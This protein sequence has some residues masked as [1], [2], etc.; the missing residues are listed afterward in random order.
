[1]SN[2]RTSMLFSKRTAN[3]HA[4]LLFSHAYGPRHKCLQSRPQ[5]GFLMPI[6]REP[7]PDL[8]ERRLLPK[9]RDR[10]RMLTQQQ[11]ALDRI[12][13]EAEGTQQAHGRRTRSTAGGDARK[14]RGIPAI[15]RDGIGGA[16]PGTRPDT[17][18]WL[19]KDAA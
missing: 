19:G 3:P 12:I 8:D 17:L 7:Q 4:R 14:L 18:Q 9:F 5:A 10:T 15:S 13:R 6:E 11:H 16:V 1:M 2:V